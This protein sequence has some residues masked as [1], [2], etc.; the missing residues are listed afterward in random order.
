M[1][2]P[3][4]RP[5]L[6]ALALLS[7]AAPAMP[8]TGTAAAG[9]PV[10]A[11]Y[12]FVPGDVIEVT[13]SSH[14]GLDRTLAIQPDGR[15]EYPGLGEIVAAGL[16]PA[17]LASRIQQGLNADLIDPK[18]TVSLKE[19]NAA[20]QPRVSVLGAVR[21]PGVFELKVNGSLAELL[22]AA[23]GPTPVADLRRVTITHPGTDKQRI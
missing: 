3:S 16:T 17:Q 1:F 14:E 4:P 12:Q 21:S 13:V 8:D 9:A 7:L 20:S 23:G 5:L 11:S 15:I 10:P 19:K 6:L 22:A 18:V 2:V